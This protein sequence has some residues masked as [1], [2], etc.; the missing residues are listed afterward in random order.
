MPGNRSILNLSYATAA[1]LPSTT[2]IVPTISAPARADS[3][4]RV[5]GLTGTPTRPRANW[6]GCTDYGGMFGWTG[7]G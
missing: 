2:Q 7:A 5:G 1:N 6:L 3:A 4:N